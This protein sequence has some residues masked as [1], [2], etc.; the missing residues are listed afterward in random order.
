MSNFFGSQSESSIPGSG[1]RVELSA[2]MRQ[3]YLW[4]ATGLLVTAAV[5]VS[6]TTVPALANLVLQ[7]GVLIGAVILELVLV[8]ALSFGLR[9]MSPGLAIVM[10]FLYAAVNGF[11]LSIIFWA[12]ELGTIGAAFLTTAGLFGAMTVFA[13]TTKTDLTKYRTYFI[14]ALIGLIIASVVNIF[15][16]SSG[17][18]FIISI[19]GVLIFTGLTAYDTQRIARMAADPAIQ[20]DGNLMM[21]LSIMGALHLYLDFINMFLYLLRLFGRRN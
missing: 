3:V 5:A 17:F 8:L 20:S 2:L 7:P 4:M 13:Y 12:Y 10:F 14:M 11:T 21:K 16:R 1:L 19:A 15:L 6:V 9:R 18:D